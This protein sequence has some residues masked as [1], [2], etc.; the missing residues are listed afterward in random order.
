MGKFRKYLREE[1]MD[2]QMLFEASAQSQI[3][4]QHGDN[5]LARAKLTNRGTRP[6]NVRPFDADDPIYQKMRGAGTPEHKEAL[7]HHVLGLPNHDNPH[8]REFHNQ[9]PPLFRQTMRVDT[10]RQYDQENVTTATNLHK[11]HPEHVNWM[12]TRFANNGIT[13]VEDIHSRAIPALKNYT[14]LVASGKMKKESLSKWKT[15]PE[16]ENAVRNALPK[17]VGKLEAHE[18]DHIGEN[19]HWDVYHP[20]TANAACVLGDGTNWC[21]AKSHNRYDHYNK[22]GP[23][24]IFVPKNPDH[25]R[26]RY[27]LH[28]PSAQLRDADEIDVISPS[29]VMLSQ[30][31]ASGKAARPLPPEYLN[32]P[33]HGKHWKAHEINHELQTPEM[34]DEVIQAR[35]R[36][37]H[38]EYESGYTPGL[39]I[40]EPSDQKRINDLI[41]KIPDIQKDEKSLHKDHLEKFHENL[42]DDLNN[43]MDDHSDDMD[44]QEIHD[45]QRAVWNVTKKHANHQRH[46]MHLNT[47][48]DSFL[49]HTTIAPDVHKEMMHEVQTR[50]ATSPGLHIRTSEYAKTLINHPSTTPENKE[51][52]KGIAYD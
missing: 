29:S 5:I 40:G 4:K 36:G 16:L 51:L 27:Q 31:K 44:D 3:I 20:K 6:D 22:Q 26:E 21:T 46:E 49:R 19:E 12:L 8:H 2:Q 45:M 15:L 43:H 32:H 10:S 13:H 37:G 39:H 7:V 42:L 23:M 24:H 47:S 33:D 1:Y 38:Y 9:L 25:A 28:A 11:T 14:S 52:L 17:H 48:M 30:K 34:A 35:I 41:S 50:H 18:Y